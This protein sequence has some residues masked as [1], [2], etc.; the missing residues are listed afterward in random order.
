MHLTSRL[1][2][3]HPKT[4]KLHSLAGVMSKV[5]QYIGFKTREGKILEPSQVSF[6]LIHHYVH[7]NYGTFGFISNA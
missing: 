2:E 7:V 6:L 1:A 3:V 5:W 4:Y